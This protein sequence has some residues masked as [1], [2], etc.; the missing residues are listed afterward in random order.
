MEGIAHGNTLYARNEK[1]G[2]L[3]GAAC[4]MGATESSEALA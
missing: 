2:Y 4:S 1:Q 3:K